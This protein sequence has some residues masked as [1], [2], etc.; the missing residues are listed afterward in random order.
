MAAGL[1]PEAVGDI[2]ISDRPRND[3][4]FRACANDDQIRRQFHHIQ[5][6]PQE[7]STGPATKISLDVSPTH[8]MRTI[9]KTNMEVSLEEGLR[10]TIECFKKALYD[11]VAGARRLVLRTQ[12][13]CSCA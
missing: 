12:T 4:G 11:G 13:K 9:L 7:K 5:Y 8:Q 2:L 10:K 1:V 6:V 3:R